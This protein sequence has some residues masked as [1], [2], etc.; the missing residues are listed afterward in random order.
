M[1]PCHRGDTP[2]GSPVIAGTGAPA[3]DSAQTEGPTGP[4]PNEPRPRRDITRETLTFPPHGRTSRGSKGIFV[5]FFGIMIAIVTF[6][7][8]VTFNTDS[9]EQ[10]IG[11][12]NT[13][14]AEIY[15]T[16]AAGSTSTAAALGV[17]AGGSP[18]VPAIASPDVDSSALIG[19][20]TPLA[21]TP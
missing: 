10:A 4:M 2:I 9:R 14:T 15:Q 8:Y 18:T 20:S 13:E 17:P 16:A 12:F 5:I 1:V 21:A 7:L 3:D 19:T 6:A 11:D